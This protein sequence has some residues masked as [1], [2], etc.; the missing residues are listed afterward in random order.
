MVP[1]TSSASNPAY[2]RIGNA[3]GFD[4]PADQ[5]DLLR[6]IGRHFGAI[7][8]VLGIFGLPVGFT[9]AFEHRGDVLRLKLLLSF[10]SMLLKM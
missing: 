7:G 1:I 6:Q 10:R 9:D 5:R 4:Q 2:C 8:F 3:H